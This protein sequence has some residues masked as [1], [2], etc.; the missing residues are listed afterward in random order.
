MFDNLQAANNH[1]SKLNLEIE[2]LTIE[3]DEL[4]RFKQIEQ[5]K[6]QWVDQNGISLADPRFDSEIIGKFQFLNFFSKM[7]RQLLYNLSY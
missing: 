3:N 5:Q 4:R 6:K 2:K 1:I 7:R